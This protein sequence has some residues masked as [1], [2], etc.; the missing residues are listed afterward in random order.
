MVFKWTLIIFGTVAIALFLLG[1]VL[2]FL[3]PPR[4]GRPRPPVL[5]TVERALR[6]TVLVPIGVAVVLLALAL[7]G[8]P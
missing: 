6:W 7:S 3:N 8:R 2:A 1:K 4:P 5:K